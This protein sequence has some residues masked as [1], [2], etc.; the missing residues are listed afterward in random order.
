MPEGINQHESQRGLIIHDIELSLEG[1]TFR[2]YRSWTSPHPSCDNRPWFSPLGVAVQVVYL[3]G[4]TISLRKKSLQNFLL[5]LTSSAKTRR[6][7]MRAD[8]TCIV[9]MRAPSKLDGFRRR[10]PG[11]KSE[12]PTTLPVIATHCRAGNQFSAFLD[13]IKSNHRRV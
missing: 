13:I 8:R 3:Q 1:K 5:P 7:V 6:R 11:R 10:E 4:H 12:E 2:T 9:R